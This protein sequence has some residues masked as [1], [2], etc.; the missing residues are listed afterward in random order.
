MSDA[1][2]IAASA[3]DLRDRPSVDEASPLA[4]MPL[5]LTVTTN[6]VVAVPAVVAD[7]ETEVTGG[8]PLTE[9]P[10]ATSKLAAVTP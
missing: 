4:V 8:L 1:V 3:E 2:L 9:L 7:G 5:V 10:L 6:V